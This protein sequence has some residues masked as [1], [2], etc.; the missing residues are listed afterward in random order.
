MIFP[1]PVN[2]PCIDDAASLGSFSSEAPDSLLFRSFFFRGQV[3]NGD[4]NSFFACHGLCTSSISQADADLC[5]WNNAAECL[6]RKQFLNAELTCS[7]TCPDGTAQSYTVPAGWFMGETQ[8]Q[9]D[10]LASQFCSSSL[11]FICD[12]GDPM[13]IKRP[14]PPLKMMWNEEQ[15]CEG[16]CA[17]GG[18]SAIVPTGYVYGLGQA[19]A[20]KI[21]QEICE[22]RLTGIGCLSSFP[23]GWCRGTDIG[24][25][26][27]VLA[28]LVNNPPYTWD[29]F[30]VLP[31]GLS[32]EYV[33]HTARLFGTVT[34]APGQYGFQLT[35]TDSK[36]STS[37]RTYSFTIMEITSNDPLSEGIMDHPYSFTLLNTGGDPA[38]KWAVL[39]GG[40]PNGCTLDQTTGEISGTPTLFGTF[41]FR[42]QLTDKN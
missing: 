13:L 3:W 28:W 1:C 22:A 36:G 12:G 19:A 18:R 37:W 40:L 8:A 34:A 15:T 39:S 21:A 31:T 2:A 33:G 24:N 16:L 9:A 7:E 4:I 17:Y 14:P 23:R 41:S 5:A 26:F 20:N 38:L 30:G 6:L 11:S 42:V 35:V 25:N 27:V 10:A 32:I 29:L